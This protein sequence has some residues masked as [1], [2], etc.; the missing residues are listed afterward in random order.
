M[1]TQC[2]SLIT[3]QCFPKMDLLADV[4]IILWVEKTVVRAVWNQHLSNF[5]KSHF[6]LGREEE[7]MYPFLVWRKND[8]SEWDKLRL[9][10]DRVEI[11][12]RLRDEASETDMRPKTN[13]MEA[14]WI[15]S[16]SFR[17]L[18]GPV[19]KIGIPNSRR[20]RANVH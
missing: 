5:P 8:V 1:A 13:F 12:W 19:W 2:Q 4:A 18:T 7:E 6:W 20:G 16:R 11:E 9:A 10:S 14:L 3:A 17:S 15:S